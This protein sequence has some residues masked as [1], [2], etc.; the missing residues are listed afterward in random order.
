[1]IVIIFSS[2]I[3]EANEISV[4]PEEETNKNLNEGNSPYK[5]EAIDVFREISEDALK[6]LEEVLK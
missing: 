1:M 4:T 6:E 2:D 3:S 5:F